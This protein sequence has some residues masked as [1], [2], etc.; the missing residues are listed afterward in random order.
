MTGIPKR[1]PYRP[2][3]MNY[4]QGNPVNGPLGPVFGD[5]MPCLLYTSP[6]PRD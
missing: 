1:G 6:S 5:A 2:L 4:A 3:A